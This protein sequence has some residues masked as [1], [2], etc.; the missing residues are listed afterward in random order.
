MLGGMGLFVAAPAEAVPTGIAAT[1][2]PYANLPQTGQAFA[3]QM[4]ADPAGNLYI[5]DSR[6]CD[7]Y[8]VQA[9]N[10][11]A[12][13]G[14]L[15]NTTGGTWC[16]GR[17]YGLAYASING[18]PV[19]I[20][21]GNGGSIFEIPLDGITAPSP[22]T[23][24]SGTSNISYDVATDTLASFSLDGTVLEFPSFSHCSQA[25]QCASVPVTLTGTGNTTNWGIAL[26]GNNLLVQADAQLLGQAPLSGGAVTPFG[27]TDPTNNYFGYY[28]TMS[29]D[30]AGDAFAMDPSG[31]FW[32]VPAGTTT[33]IP[34]TFATPIPSDAVGSNYAMVFSNGHL[35]MLNNDTGEQITEISIE[36]TPVTV[37]TTIPAVTPASLAATGTNLGGLLGVSLVFLGLGG[38]AFMSL[39]RRRRQA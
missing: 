1:S 22:V 23:T 24:N 31:D 8:E 12:A 20:Y 35:F 5:G 11:S 30:S 39:Q 14:V 28:L 19:L 7:I 10:P 27:P 2:S 3:G 33:A 17:A 15:P 38:L 16:P 21:S 34:L 25:A 29:T 9:A 26:T 4:A 37:P 36:S 6:G 13:P 32:E 18:S